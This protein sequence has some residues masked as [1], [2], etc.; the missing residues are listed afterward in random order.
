[1][2]WTGPTV[3]AVALSVLLGLLRVVLITSGHD[4]DPALTAAFTGSVSLSLAL[5]ASHILRK[6]G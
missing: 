1:M 3:T 6:D 4:N 5:L 2:D